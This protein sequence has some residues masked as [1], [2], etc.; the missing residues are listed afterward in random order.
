MGALLAGVVGV[1]A[2]G[3]QSPQPRNQG[4]TL[5]VSNEAL[6]LTSRIEQALHVGDERLA[7]GLIDELAALGDG[8]VATP[9]SRV[10]YPVWRQTLR[11][12]QQFP[13]SAIEL[14]RQL[15]DAETATLLDEARTRGDLDRL[16]RL[17]RRYP[18][19]A[20]WPQIGQELAAE[21][22]DRGRFGEA[23][24]VLRDLLRAGASDDDSLRSQLVVALG[25]AGAIQPAR[26]L[27]TALRSRS[28][29]PPNPRRQQR[30][31]LLDR[32]L[33]ELEHRQ[34]TA[35]GSISMA[36]R[37]G[38]LWTCPLQKDMREGSAGADDV[39]HAIDV[40]RELPAYRAAV[41]EGVLAIRAAGRLRVLDAETLVRLWG[42]DAEPEEPVASITPDA[43]ILGELAPARAAVEWSPETAA[44]F[45]DHL[46]Q[47]VSIAA[48]LVLAI[49]GTI[50]AEVPLTTGMFPGMGRTQ[51]SR[52]NEL[53][54]RDPRDGHIV[55]RTADPPSNP[56]FD[57]AFQGVP[58]L[59]GGRL[60]APIQRGDRLN[61]ALIDPADGRLLREVPLIGPP[62]YFPAGGGRCFLLADA[63]ALYV[64]TGNGVVAALTPRELHWKWATVYP[65]T[66]VA[67][68]VRFWWQ[69]RQGPEPIHA[70]PPILAGDLLIVAPGDARE[71]LGIDRFSGEQRWHIPRDRY[72]FLLGA[73]ADG[74]MI[75]GDE[76][77]CLDLHSPNLRH[78]RWRSVPLAITGR[79]VVR[80]GRLFIPTATGIVV[81][82]GNTGK[83]IAD[84]EPALAG[85]DDAAPAWAARRPPRVANLALAGDALLAVTP[86]QVVKYPDPLATRA[87]LAGATQPTGDARAALVLAWLDVFENHDRHA[88]DRL[89]NVQPHDRRLAA[90][91]DRLREVALLRQAANLPAGTQRLDL[92]RRARDLAAAPSLQAALSLQ[93]GYTLE[94][95]ERYGAALAQYGEVLGRSNGGVIAARSEGLQVAAWLEAARHIA[96]IAPRTD[97]AA[98]EQLV[99]QIVAQED[100]SDRSALALRHLYTALRDDP[101][102]SLVGLH[103]ACRKIP[104]EQ[105]L[106]YLPDDTER[107]PPA[108]RRRLLLERWD[109]HVSLGM[110]DLA[111]D[112]REAW[113]ALDK[114]ETGGQTPASR[115][116]MPATLSASA[117]R[118]RVAALRLAQRKLQQDRGKPFTAALSRQWK[119]PACELLFD[120][121]RPLAATSLWMLTADLSRR[122]I[123]LVNTFKH[124]QAQRQTED[125]LAHV[126]G[127][128]ASA[129]DMVRGGGERE[130]WPVTRFDPLAVVP[131]PGGVVCVGLGPER[132]AGRRQWERAVPAW[133]AIPDDYADRALACSA[134]FCLL[135]RRN[136]VE[137]LDWADGRLL[138]R[139]NLAD[140]NVRRLDAVGNHLLLIGEDRRVWVIDARDGRHLRPVDT[141]PTTPRRVDVVADMLIVWGAD[142]VVGIDARTLERVWGRACSAVVDTTPAAGQPWLAY[143]TRDSDNW[144]MFD[145]RSGKA[146]AGGT[147]G[148]FSAVTA[149]VAGGERIFVGGRV[150]WRDDQNR[151]VVSRIV[152]LD[153]H[154]GNM[155]WSR[156]FC[157]GVTINATQLAANPRLIP[158]LLASA[159]EEQASDV[160][161]PAIQLVDKATGRLHDPLPIGDDFRRL[162]EATCE[163]MLIATPARVI[164]Q[165]GGNLIAYGN[166]PLDRM[167]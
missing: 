160:E 2:A 47:A 123:T 45:S 63:T 21:L 11:L 75:G 81:I 137:M 112:D 8:L 111:R 34:A 140:L 44:L 83:V 122:K 22:L 46:G 115:P 100:P 86:R 50:G 17:F 127:L 5:P 80:G 110:L 92:L 161:T 4:A 37:R 41:G 36:L 23:V 10:Y 74:L 32:W 95:M 9:A 145:V 119:A 125:R 153:A 108:V 15:H 70:D 132:Y 27:L 62:T 90:A 167:P 149:I 48:G 57:V 113:A 3:A 28:V 43:R 33:K 133:R 14:Y 1:V 134:G 52:R 69:P 104:P 51:A 151:N 138:W 61:L 79:G 73:T 106:R 129:G 114:A 78:P 126:S 19:S 117:Q 118:R 130:A 40:L 25:G 164:V 150:G 7:A 31:A 166:S 146:V 152:T 124:Q 158:V 55:W 128:G 156:E 67:A 39:A 58:L 91:C 102:R 98:V 103:L 16:R 35:G 97:R 93:L 131:V 165:A 20:L 71:L 157:T 87:R 141:G 105:K 54:A 109:A 13:D 18:L 99:E 121:R 12:A 148:E 107:W 29:A 6:L 53:I 163:M 64:C 26:R 30:L 66:A 136:R 84:Q 155:L 159:A 143:R 85:G 162:T 142:H 65:S 76:V 38:A 49:E 135:P 89:A 56:L 139:R 88:L 42:V 59:L 77:I 96:E 116:A 72:P 101:L 68:Q 94:E 147:L 154:N 144:R 82:D 60:V 120:S 24:G